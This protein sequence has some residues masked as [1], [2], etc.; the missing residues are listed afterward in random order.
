MERMMEIM[1]INHLDKWST[2]LK[3]S[4]GVFS[5]LADKWR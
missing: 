4:R 5:S 3:D 1:E 2:K